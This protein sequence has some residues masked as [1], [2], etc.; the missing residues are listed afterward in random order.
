[1]LK[2]IARDEDTQRVHKVKDKDE[3]ESLYNVINSESSTFVYRDSDANPTEPPR[4]IFYNEADALEDQI[5]FPE[6]HEDPSSVP[7]HQWTDGLHQYENN[8][9]LP[10]ELYM[11]RVLYGLDDS[12]DEDAN[13]ASRM[14][15]ED[16]ESG[17]SDDEPLES[18]T[19]D[20]TRAISK[21][22]IK[23]NEPAVAQVYYKS[24]EI[25]ALMS[26]WHMDLPKPDLP[27]VEEEF[28]YWLDWDKSKG[29][30]FSSLLLLCD[31]LC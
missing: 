28:I 24:N 1:M 12:D 18:D 2:T 5:L 9:R 15:L 29:T 26:K 22:A 23:D 27:S 16:V 13:M 8:P 3:K 25:A 30:Y 6:A 17:E 31:A 14:P 20:A 19:N 7:F 21:V 11:R 10:M 4:H